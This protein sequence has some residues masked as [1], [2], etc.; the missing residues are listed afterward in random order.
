[1]FKKIRQT[2]LLCS[3]AALA[4]ATLSAHAADQF[5]DDKIKIG[6]LGDMS[7]VYATGYSGPGGVAAVKMAV[8]DFGGE[9]DGHP[10]EVVSADHQNKADRAS[11]TARRWIDEDHVDVIVDLT[12]SAVGLAV[13][14]L[15]SNK[16]VITLNTGSA[17]AELTNDACTKYGIHYGY[18]THGLA[19]GTATGIVENGGDS[20]FF[21]TADYAFGHSLQANTTEVVEELG[22]SVLGG[23]AAPLGTNDFASYLIQ[24][25][26]SGAEVVA[27]ANAGQDA[28]N[29]AKQAG[30][31]GIV[32][33]GQQLVGLL[34]LLSNIQSLGLKTAQGL[35]FTASWYWNQDAE[36]RE[37]TQRYLDY[38]DGAAPTSI[39]AAM[40][41]AITS[42]LQAVAAAGT[43]DGDAV[44]EELGNMEINDF[45]AKGAYIREDGL[46]M[47]T[48]HLLKVKKP[49][50]SEGKW[51]L[52]EVVGDIPAEDAYPALADTTCPRVQ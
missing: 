46:L 8:E 2:A 40:Y 41:S 25:Q 31:Y 24:A 51:D 13:Q 23:V 49:D 33:G 48:L 6:V 21:I 16:G 39:H 15:A 32:A 7:G 44:R 17:T 10:I 37:W 42:Y 38:S 5:S 26:N 18:D 12:N 45:F 34:F 1:M 28:V 9:I 22:G 19:V 20:W 29:S 11:S 35:Q 43:D 52:A 50:E 47:N 14:Q 30:S 27:L 4:T 3:A 36:S